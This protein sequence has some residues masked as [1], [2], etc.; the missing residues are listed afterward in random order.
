MT[1]RAAP[2][3]DGSATCA[4]KDTV[5][6]LRGRLHL[7]QPP[8]GHRPGTDALLLAAT[9]PSSTQGGLVVDLG[10]GIGTVGL[11]AAL[12]A[13][14]I[15][16]VLVE[17]E[18]ELLACAAHNVTHN[19]L[20]ERV[21]VVAQDVFARATPAF[22]ALRGAADIVLTNPPWTEAGRDRAS[23]DELR[24]RA[25]HFDAPGNARDEAGREP[26]DTAPSGP[27]GEAG[28]QPLSLWLRRAA[29]LLRP[30]GRLMLIHRADRLD[31]ILAALPRHLGHRVVLPIHPRAQ[32]PAHRIIVG[33]V[34]DSRAPLRLLPGLVLHADGGFTPQAVALHEGSSGL[35]LWP[36][37]G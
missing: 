7:V 1:D 32:E 20:G 12:R 28:T 9:V 5:A 31:E 11:A 22:A 13:P 33:A 10:A 24:R 8:R 37:A 17:R 35:A 25:H 2:A 30:G 3:R 18:P 6:L 26:A 27:T 21:R 16:T 4:S 29:A 15:H 34:R 14:A 36:D 19:A 23:P